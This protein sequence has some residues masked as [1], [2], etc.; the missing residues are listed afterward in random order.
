MAMGSDTGGSI[1][2]PSSL[3]GVTGLKPT[4]GAVSLRGA[5][6]MCPSFDTAGPL[7]NS[8]AD[9]RLAWSV[10]AGFDPDDL[11]SR[12]APAAAAPSN[13]ARLR[14]AIPL[15]FMR[16]ATPEVKD[17]VEAAARV[18]ESLGMVIDEI[19][20]PS[21][22]DAGAAFLYGFAE[23]ANRYRDLW[24]DKRVH[25]QV[26]GLITLG[27]NTSGAD[28]A[29][30]YDTLLKVRRDFEW[31][32]TSAD[33]LLA[34]CTP[35]PAPVIPKEEEAVGRTDTTVLLA[36]LTLPVNVAGLPSL[37]VP[38]GFAGGLPLGAQLIGR[39]WSEELLLSVGEAFQQATDWHTREPGAF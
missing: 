4:H 18:L 37:A 25:P 34:P 35:T 30:A 8:A 24:D 29:S 16:R 36:S 10:L 20:G 39:A 32:L 5:M 9:C 14:V 6:P 22:D 1:R 19:E 7:A 27:R 28:A 38:C 3:C 31:A 11:H 2:I 13:P 26:A 23:L 15:T 17:A 12:Q 21:L 33:L